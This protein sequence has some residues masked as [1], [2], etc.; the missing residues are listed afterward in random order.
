[1]SIALLLGPI[2]SLFQP[3]IH[4]GMALTMLIQGYLCGYLALEILKDEGN[5]QKG[6]AVLVGAVLATKGAAW[7][8]G[9]G[10]ILWLLLEKDWTTAGRSVAEVTIVSEDSA[11]AK[12]AE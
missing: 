9:I 1:M 12:K 5:L 6:I 10:I 4:I 3:G 8:L 2:V 11:Q 7:G